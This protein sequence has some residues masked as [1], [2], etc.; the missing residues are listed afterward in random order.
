MIEIRE[1]R[2]RL[3]PEI[4][5]GFADLCEELI[6]TTSIRCA[7]DEF[8]VPFRLRMSVTFNRSLSCEIHVQF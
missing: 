1:E 6:V 4:A 8:Q 2:T 3:N 7:D 5:S